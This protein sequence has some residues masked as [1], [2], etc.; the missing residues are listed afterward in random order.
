[1]SQSLIP[2]FITVFLNDQILEYT[3]QSR[4]NTTQTSGSLTEGCDFTLNKMET[5]EHPE[6]LYLPSC[7]PLFRLRINVYSLNQHECYL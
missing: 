3:V 5:A 7:F 1:M 4:P 6:S 2:A